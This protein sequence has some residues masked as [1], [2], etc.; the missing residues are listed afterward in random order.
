MAEEN[1][2]APKIYTMPIEAVEK[3]IAS[4]DSILDNAADILSV[5]ATEDPIDLKVTSL[6]C[7][8]FSSNYHIRKI[9]KANLTLNTIQL[10]EKKE[11]VVLL[12]EADL[13]IVENGVLSNSFTKRELLKL[14]YSLALH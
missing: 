13:T 11:K 9:L 4:S 6:L 12:S 10:K 2:K 1:E 7:D 3:M 5:K 8:A 14:N